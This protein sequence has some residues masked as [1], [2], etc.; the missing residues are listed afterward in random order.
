MAGT[1]L[2]KT[3][4]PTLKKWVLMRRPVRIPIF[5]N[6]LDA[7]AIDDLLDVDLAETYDDIADY[8]I[9]RDNSNGKSNKYKNIPKTNNKKTTKES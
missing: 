6:L 9:N 1:V 2:V 7:Y 8:K 4:E 3:Y 5:S